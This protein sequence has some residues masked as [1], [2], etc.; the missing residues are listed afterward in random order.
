ML[1][2]PELNRIVDGLGSMLAR[3]LGWL[4]TALSVL[5]VISYT[6]LGLSFVAEEQ[7]PLESPP[8]KENRES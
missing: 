8:N 7:K 1:I 2:A 5:A 6:R 3:L 4:V